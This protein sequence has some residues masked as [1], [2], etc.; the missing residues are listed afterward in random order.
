MTSILCGCLVTRLLDRLQ[1]VASSLALRVGQVMPQARRADR[2]APAP[3]GS[4]GL[5]PRLLTESA[6]Q[7]PSCSPL[8]FTPS[9]DLPGPKV[10]SRRYTGPSRTARLRTG[11]CALLPFVL[12]A[13]NGR[14]PPL[15][16]RCPSCLDRFL[17][18]DRQAAKGGKRTLAFDLPT[19]ALRFASD[20]RSN[21]LL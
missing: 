10:S 21:P 17:P 15:P 14:S 2:A 4:C 5:N 16:S 8:T 3:L 6:C 12:G 13:A 11:F 9:M 1:P 7:S 20:L 18:L 19:P